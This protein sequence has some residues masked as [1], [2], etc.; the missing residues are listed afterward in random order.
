[1]R[2]SR[3][4]PGFDVASRIVSSPFGPTSIDM[5]T[6]HRVDPGSAIP[7]CSQRLPKV[8]EAAAVAGDPKPDRV[9]VGRARGREQVVPAHGV[10]ADL[11][12]ALIPRRPQRRA[13]R[14]EDRARHLARVAA[15]H[16]SVGSSARNRTRSPTGSLDV[17]DAK[18]RAGGAVPAQPVPPLTTCIASI[19]GTS[20]VVVGANG[21][22]ARRAA[23]TAEERGRPHG[24]RREVGPGSRE[25]RG[26]SGWRPRGG[27]CRSAHA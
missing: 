14:D 22:T 10:F 17:G 25:D 2:T 27:S 15:E 13:G 4:S 12:D 1:M 20:S 18:R 19:A 7:N 6:S 16:R 21:T 26:A 23:R 8:G 5:N 11:S 24:A 3:W 9:V